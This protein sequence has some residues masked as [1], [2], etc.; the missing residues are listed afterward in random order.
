MLNSFQSCCAFRETKRIGVLVG[1]ISCSHSL[2]SHFCTY[3][4][5]VSLNL[6]SATKTELL[7]S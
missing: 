6:I 2:G 1:T 7:G 5:I 4:G 3:I